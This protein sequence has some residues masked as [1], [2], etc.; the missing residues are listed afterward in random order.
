MTSA[1]GL[2]GILKIGAL[3]PSAKNRIGLPDEFPTAAFFNLLKHT[4][5][6]MS[7]KDIALQCA[8]LLHHS[9]QQS[10]VMLS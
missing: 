4:Y 6:Q 7:P 1:Q 2:L 3:L 5:Q 10:G 9:K 8:K